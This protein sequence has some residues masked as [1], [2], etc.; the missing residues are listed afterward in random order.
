MD[1]KSHWYR[2]TSEGMVFN[3][4]E[5]PAESMLYRLRNGVLRRIR[6]D[7]EQ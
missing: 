3:A 6:K 2:A 1:E 4:P 7:V 5:I